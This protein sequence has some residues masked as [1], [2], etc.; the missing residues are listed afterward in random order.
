MAYTPDG[1]D[2][3]FKGGKDGVDV[4]A[5]NL[6]TGKTQ[7]AQIDPPTWHSLITG[8]DFK[9]DSVMNGD[10]MR[11]LHNIGVPVGKAMDALDE[12]AKGLAN[13]ILPHANPPHRIVDGEDIDADTGA[14]GGQPKQGA[15][16]RASQVQNPVNKEFAGAP[17]GKVTSSSLGPPTEG[18]E[19]A[20]TS[21]RDQYG[22]K[23]ANP[24]S[25]EYGGKHISED[26]GQRVNGPAAD[27][28]SWVDSQG[29]RHAIPQSS[30]A[31][32]SRFDFSSQKPSEGGATPY[33]TSKGTTPGITPGA[34][35]SGG[36]AKS[37]NNADEKQGPITTVKYGVRHTEGTPDTPINY[38]PSPP[39]TG[40]G[41]R[42]SGGDDGSR[43]GDGGGGGN[44]GGSRVPHYGG[45]GVRR[46][47]RGRRADAGDQD[48]DVASNESQGGA[49]APAPGQQQS[50]S[51]EQGRQQSTSQGQQQGRQQSASQDQAPQ[52]DPNAGQVAPKQHAL[53]QVG[54]SSNINGVSYTKGRDGQWYPSN[55]QA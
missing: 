25:V 8:P 48:T 18:D 15:E 46:G 49:S 52:Q 36:D 27:S 11:V 44:R 20:D 47:G 19:S 34:K 54:A 29:N 10:F 22:V 17:V 45:G 30:G 37:D 26:T 39:Q 7:S 53:L 9:F 50:A 40:G 35:G 31:D 13:K 41:G 38:P 28:T 1:N 21:T 51:Q 42:S 43:S 24:M 6:G 12:G 33:S 16:I 32:P 2:V 3:Q 23:H 5:T 55:A 14:G 4:S